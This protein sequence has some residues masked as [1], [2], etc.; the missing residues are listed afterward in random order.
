MITLGSILVIVATI[1]SHIQQI[2]EFNEFVQGDLEDM[3]S[4]ELPQGFKSKR[5][6]QV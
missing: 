4:I 2:D 5:E 1:H 3:T 6:I